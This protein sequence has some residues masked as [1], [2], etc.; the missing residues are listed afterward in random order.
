MAARAT[1]TL[2]TLTTVTTVTAKA[3]P[4]CR[5]ESPPPRTNS[6]RPLAHESKRSMHS[7]PICYN[8]LTPVAS[9]TSLMPDKH[10]LHLCLPGPRH[11]LAKDPNAE[12]LCA[13]SVC[14]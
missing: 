6:R 2:T 11:C 7:E 4:E 3:P 1:G 12:I 14:Q 8:A 13:Y 9:S 10:Q 5:F